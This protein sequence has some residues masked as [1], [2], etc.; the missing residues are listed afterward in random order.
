MVQRMMRMLRELRGLREYMWMREG[1]SR[2]G[3]AG[4]GDA[5]IGA[6]GLWMSVVVGWH[7]AIA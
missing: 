5:D 1:R 4:A 7:W 3:T 6:A 2:T